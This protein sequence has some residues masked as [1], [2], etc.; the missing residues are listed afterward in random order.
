MKLLLVNFVFAVTVDAGVAE[1]LVDLGE[2]GGI[3]VTVRTHTGETV[4][5][6]DA[7]STVVARIDGAFVNVDVTH[8]T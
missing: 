5:F 7:G 1:T 2:A 8:C 6:I 3:V 4:D